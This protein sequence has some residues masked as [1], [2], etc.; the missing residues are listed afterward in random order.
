MMLREPARS[1]WQKHRH[2]VERLRGEAGGAGRLMLGGGSILGA[3][4]EHRRSTDIDVLLPDRE[5]LND[6]HPDGPNDLAAATGGEASE[7]WKDRVKVAVED[8]M[9]DITAAAP[10]LPGMETRGDVEGREETVLA[11]AQILRGKLNRTHKGVTRDAF[12]LVS[13]A[14]ADENALQQA[15][16]ALTRKE[17]QTVCRNLINANDDMADEAEQSLGEIDPA[18]ETDLQRLGHNA[19]IAVMEARYTHVRVRTA[20]GAIIIES[21]TGK[22]PLPAERYAGTSAEEALTKSGIGEYLSSNTTAGRRTVAAALDKLLRRREDA[23]VFDSDD[24]RPWERSDGVLGTARRKP[25]RVGGDPNVPPPD[26][27]GGGAGATPPRT[28][29]RNPR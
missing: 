8:G 29:D 1:I 21:R 2:A 18:F 12:D 16:N 6:A 7:M 3:R 10:L 4:W 5:A 27:K 26:R 22:G 17:W 25:T 11:N 14:R 23:I 9:L 20:D 19:A 15:T 13:A 24:T 28:T